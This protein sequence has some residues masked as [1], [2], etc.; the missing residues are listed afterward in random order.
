MDSTVKTQKGENMNILQQLFS[1]KNEYINNKKYKYITLFGIKIKS[2]AEQP[3]TLLYHLDRYNER[4]NWPRYELSQEQI[5]NCKL[6]ANR[7]KLLELMPKEGVFVEI[8]TAKGDYAKQ[9]LEICKP[10]KLYL[11]DFWAMGNEDWEP[12]VRERFKN[13][14]QSGQVVIL[15]GDS[16]EML[17]KIED[18]SLDFAYIDAFHDYEHPKNELNTLKNKM[19]DSGYICGHDYTRVEIIDCTQYGIIEAV[20]EFLYKNDQYELCY[21]T[22]DHLFMNPSYAIKKI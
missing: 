10:K 9:I 20:N 2:R 4:N 5:Q 21:L 8:G 12:F 16:I 19:K 6:V 22:M 11:I 1:I 7:T 3:P 17:K 15:K 18:K 14:I 13:E